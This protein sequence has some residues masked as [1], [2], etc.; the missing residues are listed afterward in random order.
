MV[1]KILDKCYICHRCLRR[2]VLRFLDRQFPVSQTTVPVSQT[3]SSQSLRQTVPSVLDSMFP[4]S[5]ADSFQ[6]LR[7]RVPSVLDSMLPVYYRQTVPSVLDRQF[8]VS[9]TV[10]P[11]VLDRKL[12]VF[13]TDGSQCL[14]QVPSSQTI[15]SQQCRWT[16]PYMS[17]GLAETY[18]QCLRHHMQD[19]Y[20][21]T[22]VILVYV[23]CCHRSVV[24]RIMAVY[25]C[26]STLTTCYVSDIFL[27]SLANL[28]QRVR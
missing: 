13:Q 23:Q 7:Q 15:S 27:L 21:V 6:C 12:P 5:Q 28:Q 25:Q 24:G 10:G 26:S 18:P 20:Q 17:S 22:L 9:Q 3:D 2:S 16:A 1:L 4:V 14:G 11:S 19:V 8:T